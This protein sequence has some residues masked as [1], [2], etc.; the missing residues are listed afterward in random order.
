M[1]TTETKFGYLLDKLQG[2]DGLERIEANDVLSLKQNDWLLHFVWHE[3]RHDLPERFRWGLCATGLLD[4]AD[5]AP[6]WGERYCFVLNLGVLVDDSTAL[7]LKTNFVCSNNL[8]SLDGMK[9]AIAQNGSSL[10]FRAYDVDFIKGAIASG[11]EVVFRVARESVLRSFI[12]QATEDLRA[13]A[14]ADIPRILF[15]DA[16]EDYKQALSVAN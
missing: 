1:T 16:A 9:A 15:G 10:E 8:R 4:S 7:K 3:D 12:H 5:E 11:N 14:H 2:V 6:F 13:V